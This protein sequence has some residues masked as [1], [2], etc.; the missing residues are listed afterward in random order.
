MVALS[1]MSMW[2]A[3]CAATCGGGRT[4]LIDYRTAPEDAQ[5][6]TIASGDD[7]ADGLA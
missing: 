5:L 7:H 2:P 6:N 1:V 3:G 4:F